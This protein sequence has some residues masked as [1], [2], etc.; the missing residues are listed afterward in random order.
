MSQATVTL[1]VQ[2][3]SEKNAWRGFANGRCHAIAISTATILQVSC[4]ALRPWRD[5]S[6]GKMTRD[7]MAGK[8]CLPRLARKSYTG[9]RRRLTMKGHACSIAARLMRHK[10]RRSTGDGRPRSFSNDHFQ[11]SMLGGRPLTTRGTG[12]HRPSHAAA[13]NE[14]SRSI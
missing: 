2:R 8:T 5:S 14:I 7:L 1:S 13:V 10:L 9:R 4:S 11:T 12:N 3:D 6:R